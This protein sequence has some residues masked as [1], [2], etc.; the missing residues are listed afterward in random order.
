M[1]GEFQ[2]EGVILF[3]VQHIF[4]RSN[5]HFAEVTLVRSEFFCRW[6]SIGFGAVIE[7]EQRFESRGDFSVRANWER[8]KH[9]LV[10]RQR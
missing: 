3:V 10:V 6:Y 2:F 4:Q 8:Q 5:W 9:L 1:S 7:T